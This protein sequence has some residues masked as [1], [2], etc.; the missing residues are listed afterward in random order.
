MLK[1]VNIPFDAY[2]ELPPIFEDRQ[3]FAMKA[4]P[5]F[6]GLSGTKSPPKTGV[7]LGGFWPR[8]YTARRNA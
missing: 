2:I 5:H 7:V 8:G 1:P 6:N 3:R 4:T